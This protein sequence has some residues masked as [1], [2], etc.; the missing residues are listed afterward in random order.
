MSVI[1]IL[2]SIVE[3][4]KN[5]SNINIHFDTLMKSKLVSLFI[6][7]LVILIKKICS[8]LSNLLR[9]LKKILYPK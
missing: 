5:A 7:C 6:V 2:Q 4:T 9:A 3:T 1:K 8:F